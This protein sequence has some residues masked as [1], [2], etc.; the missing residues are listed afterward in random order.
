[1]N[2]KEGLWGLKS[3]EGGMDKRGYWEV[4]RFK[5]YYMYVY[6]NSIMKSIKYCSKRGE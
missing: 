1:M 5:V 4:K 6:E 2:I 3:V